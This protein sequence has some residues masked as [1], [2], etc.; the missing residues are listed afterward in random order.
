LQ[1]SMLRFWQGENYFELGVGLPFTKKI[2]LSVTKMSAKRATSKSQ[3]LQGIS[4]VRNRQSIGRRQAEQAC[5]AAKPR[6]AG[7]PNAYE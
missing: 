4:T 3:Y 1:K 2:T 5:N 7:F 6:W